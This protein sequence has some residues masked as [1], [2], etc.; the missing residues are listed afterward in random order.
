MESSDDTNVYIKNKEEYGATDA[1]GEE[2]L[3]AL[4]QPK[5]RRGNKN[6]LRIQTAKR[7]YTFDIIHRMLSKGMFNARATQ[8]HIRHKKHCAIKT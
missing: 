7:I 4:Y 1:M 8:W 2:K 6:L 3:V 5:H